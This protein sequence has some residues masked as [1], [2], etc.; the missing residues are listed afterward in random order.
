MKTLILSLFFVCLSLFA[1]TQHSVAISKEKID[2]A[3]DKFMKTFSEG[4]FSQ[5]IQMLKNNSFIEEE[6]I[7]KLDTSLNNQMQQVRYSYG[8]IVGF[9]FVDE[10]K[11]NNSIARRRYLLKFKRYFAVFDFTLYNN[12]LNWSIVNFDFVSNNKNLF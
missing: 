3:C 10:K 2:S 12:D 7:D 9:E 1:F 8:S 6:T 4:N 11:I 5:A